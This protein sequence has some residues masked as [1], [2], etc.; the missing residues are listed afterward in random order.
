VFIARSLKGYTLD[1]LYYVDEIGCSAV[2]QPCSVSSLA[3]IWVQEK[4][5]LKWPAAQ[6]GAFSW[7]PTKRVL[8]ITIPVTLL[9][10]LV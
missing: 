2:N 3:E 8:A 10:A 6:T 9:N 7:S 4:A 5:F 1:H